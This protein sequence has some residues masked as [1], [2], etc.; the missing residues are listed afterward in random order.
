MKHLKLLAAASA[1]V[2]IASPAFAADANSNAGADIIAPIQVSNTAPLYF[3][4][5][6]PS[7]SASDTVL[8]NSAGNKTCGSNLTCITADH[9]AAAFTVTGEA[10][11][12]YTV[13]LPSSVDIDNGAG[14]SMT[15]NNFTGSKAT[16]TLTSGTDT[17]S[18]G[19]TLTVAANQASGEY[20]GTF[21]VTVEYQ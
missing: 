10:D 14:Q 3:G 11:K 18:V 2:A 12:S 7:T 20:N 19:G 15:V 9:T 16:G 6:A 4:T 5:I 21:A 1:A 17:F 13:S 8:V